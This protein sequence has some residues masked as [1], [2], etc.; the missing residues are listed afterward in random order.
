MQSIALVRHNKTQLQSGVIA[1]RSDP[2]PLPL[3]AAQ[4]DFLQARCKGRKALASPAKRC[5]LLG[6]ELGLQD[7][8]QE[9]LLWEQ[10]FG[11]WEGKRWQDIGADHPFWQ[12]PASACPPQGE[13]FAHVMERARRFAQSQ[14][15][16]SEDC[17]ILCHAGIVR[18]F[19]AIALDL[20]PEQ[21]LKF[22]IYH[23]SLSLITRYDS[24]TWSVEAVNLTADLVTKVT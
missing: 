4:R 16:P 24:A 8:Q 1:G 23:A 11:A 22:Q 19:L 17:V 3:S 20:S 6:Q 14:A 2:D 12:D 13:S 9:E 21:A 7:L 5:R 10:D 18:S 15:F